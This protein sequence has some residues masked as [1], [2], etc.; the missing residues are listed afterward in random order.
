MVGDLLDVLLLFT[1][2]ALFYL[3]IFI[4]MSKKE[5]I[6]EETAS[7]PSGLQFFQLN[8]DSNRLTCKNCA[9]E[10]IF[11]PASVEVSYDIIPTSKIL[12][13]KELKLFFDR[14]HLSFFNRDEEK[15]SW[16]KDYHRIEQYFQ[17]SP[18]MT[19]EAVNNVGGLEFSYF[20]VTLLNSLHYCFYMDIYL[21]TFMETRKIDHQ[22]AFTTFTQFIYKYLRNHH[23]AKYQKKFLELIILILKRLGKPDNIIFIETPSLEKFGILTEEYLEAW[24][25]F[26][27]DLQDDSVIGFEMALYQLRNLSKG[28]PEGIPTQSKSKIFSLLLLC[29]YYSLV[30]DKID[31]NF[32]EPR[33]AEPLML[34]FLLR[35]LYFSTGPEDLFTLCKSKEIDRQCLYHIRK[36][37]K[38]KYF[39]EKYKFENSSH[40]ASLV[41]E[42]FKDPLLQKWDLWMF[43]IY[44][45]LVQFKSH[46][47]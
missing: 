23:T 14:F 25:R 16:E 30:I 37:T 20:I 4:L 45:I 36:K 35:F 21:P 22:E 42:I 6:N 3:G 7:F 27:Y 26:E 46:Q 1:L 19:M 9:I 24:K 33:S 41:N 39:L 43:K 32:F 34:S 31:F 38:V 44:L 13:K 12:F 47:I 11:Q 8:G 5:F 2:S 17:I 29:E 10:E 15:L 28:N 18:Y 40:Q